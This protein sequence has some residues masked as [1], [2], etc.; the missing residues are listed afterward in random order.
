MKDSKIIYPEG[1]IYLGSI[2]GR[3][4]VPDGRGKVTFEDGTV[5]EG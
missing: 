5:Y 1:R 4:L 2:H 3:T